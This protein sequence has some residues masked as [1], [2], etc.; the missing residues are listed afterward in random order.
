[1]ME[2]T[3]QN[4]PTVNSQPPVKKAGRLSALGLTLIIILSV[5]LGIGGGVGGAWLFAALD[6]QDT[7]QTVEQASTA[8]SSEGEVIADVASKVAP[9][10][11]SIITSGRSVSSYYYFDSYET[12]GAGTGIIISSDG[13]IMTNRHVV[14]E[15]TRSVTVILHDGSKYENVEVIG[16]DSLNDIAFLKIDEVDNLTPASLSNSDGTKVGQRVIAIGNA[17]GEY[18]NTVTSGIISARGRSVAVSG[19]GSV[20][21]LSNLIQTDAAINQGNSGGPLVTIDGKVIGIN[22]AIVQDAA[23]LGFAIPINDV[24]GVIEGVIADGKVSRAYIGVRYLNLTPAVAKEEDLA[25]TEGAFLSGD[26]GDAITAG[27]PADK[28]GLKAGDIITKVNNTDI[29][30]NHQLSSAIGLLRPGD[31]VKLT[32]I[33]GDD[34]FEVTL[35]LEEYEG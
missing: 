2:P 4:L 34:K 11:V 25:V 1:M 18:Q 28:A 32:V 9:S 16:R 12:V 3:M 10:V 22:T 31:K 26:G 19:E 21:N 8:I 27:S 23:G 13:Y 15:S 17:L 35:T 24:R 14:P 7:T 30:T 5:F 33:R 6:K 20:E 29:D